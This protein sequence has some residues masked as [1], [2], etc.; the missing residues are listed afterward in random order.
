MASSQT[1]A[2]KAVSKIKSG[3]ALTD[4]ELD[5]LGATPAGGGKFFTNSGSSQQS[6]QANVVETATVSAPIKSAQ[7]NL[8]VNKQDTPIEALE[9]LFFEDLTGVELIQI[10]RA[11]MLTGTANL[12]YQP[13]KNIP[14]LAMRYSPQNILALQNT[15]KE[16]FRKFP[17]FLSD[18]LPE[19]GDGTGPEGSIRYIEEGTGNLVLNI[20]DLDSDLRIEFQLLTLNSLINKTTY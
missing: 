12:E 4:Y 18:Y 16:Y 2:Q 6:Q 15:D 7:S 13:I 17:I 10:A 9:S 8:L 14:N 5:L 20:K 19:D 1:D 3:M 11:T